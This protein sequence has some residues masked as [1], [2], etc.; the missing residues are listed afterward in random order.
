[1]LFKFSCNFAFLQVCSIRRI[2]SPCPVLSAKE[3]LSLKH[4]SKALKLSTPIFSAK[5]LTC[6]QTRRPLSGTF[7]PPLLNPKKKC[8]LQLGMCSR[9]ESL[10]CDIEGF[11]S[12]GFHDSCFILDVH[13]KSTHRYIAFVYGSPTWEFAL[14]YSLEDFNLH[15]LPCRSGDSEGTGGLGAHEPFGHII[16]SSRHV[17][18]CA[19]PTEAAFS[20]SLL[21]KE[22]CGHH[23]LPAG[24]PEQLRQLSCEMSESFH[25]N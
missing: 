25:E 7:T 14:P 21:W 5:T 20:S 16:G 3:C 18:V 17:R 10:F 24:S 15:G 4:S 8:L 11:T 9:T 23:G 13:C 22:C 6:F 19:W 1:M 12:K 2:L